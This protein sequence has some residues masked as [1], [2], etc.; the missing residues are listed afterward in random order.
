MGSLNVS[1]RWRAVASCT[2]I[3]CGFIFFLQFIINSAKYGL[4]AVN[5]VLDVCGNDQAIGHDIACSSRKTIAAS[6][7]GCKAEELRLQLVI[8]AFHGFSHNHRCQLENHPLYLAGLGIEDLETCECIFASSNS[9]APLIRH[10]S[11]FHWVQFLD[12]HFEKWDT[13]KYLELSRFLYNNYVQALQIIECYSVELE[14]LKQCKDLVDADFLKWRDEE[15]EY[16][17]QVAT[18]PTA[19]TIA[20]AYVE[21]LEKL[22]H[23]EFVFGTII[24]GIFL[25]LAPLERC[26]AVS[27]RFHSSLT[28]LP[29]LR[30][31]RV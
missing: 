4:A 15:S 13:D 6:S 5:K 14:E 31:P 23:A 2:L 10:A 9:T 21:N 17:G 27:L 3:F 11:H 25:M 26:T 18:E 16:L 29:T 19:D 7:I 24:C 12:L 28:C 20:V 1:Q 8:N 30:I 22:K